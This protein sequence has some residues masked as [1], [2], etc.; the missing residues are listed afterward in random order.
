[1]NY[2]PYF[3]IIYLLINKIISQIEYRPNQKVLAYIKC[4]CNINILLNITM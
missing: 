4:A 1:M 2:T 3:A